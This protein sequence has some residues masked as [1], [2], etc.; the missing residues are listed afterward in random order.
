MERTDLSRWRTFP[1]RIW[2]AVEHIA[3]VAWRAIGIFIDTDG[4]QRAAS[5]AYYAF[6]SLFPLILLFVAIGSVWIEPARVSTA[7]IE[8]IDAYIPVTTGER[9][10]VIDTIAGVVAS[11]TRASI[12]AI[13]GLTWS[14]LRFFQA[15]VRGVN[16]AW[17]TLE[18]SWWRLPIKNLAMVGVLALVLLFGIVAPAILGTIERYWEQY[19]TI[20][21]YGVMANLF[22]LAN[23][24]LPSVVLF[25]GFAMFYKVAP[26]GKTAWADIWIAALL[27]TILLQVLRTIFV[28]YAT[29]IGDF[30]RV[31]GTFAGV[32]ALLM[33]V[34]LSGVFII[35]GA[36]I[37]A[38]E[39]EVA[40]RIAPPQPTH[41]KVG[42]PEL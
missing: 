15:L 30:N 27:V 14:S 29:S 13:L 1:E 17:G 26:R 9:S 5:F 20:Y 25:F 2:D 37:S 19:T 32:I 22:H 34:Y 24:L 10:V 42:K 28:F 11:G 33:W 39:A 31:Y 21:D 12:I 36:C 18:Y 40:G 7:I 23:S 4:E 6:F 38:A 41:A 35:F 16:R 8:F 3:K